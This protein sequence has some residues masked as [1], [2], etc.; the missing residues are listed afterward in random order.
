[1]CDIDTKKIIYK[2][3]RKK[4]DEPTSKGFLSKICKATDIYQ[5]MGLIMEE[6]GDVDKEAVDIKNKIDIDQDRI[7]NPPQV[8]EGVHKC[9]Q[10]G[11]KKTWS[12][13]LQTRS[14]DEPMTNFVTCVSC[15]KR[16]KF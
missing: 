9:S 8:E 6:C 15:G 1:M 13:Q 4:Y 5:E 3:L 12:Y 2:T 16:W 11:S 14:A 7:V 10:C